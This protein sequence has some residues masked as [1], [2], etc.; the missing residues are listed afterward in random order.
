MVAQHKRGCQEKIYNISDF[1]FDRIL[2]IA[3][4]VH[5]VSVVSEILVERTMPPPHSTVADCHHL[6]KQSMVQAARQARN[7]SHVIIFCGCS[8]ETKTL[9]TQKENA[10]S[11]RNFNGDKLFARSI[12]AQTFFTFQP[13]GPT[14][15]S[16]R[17]PANLKSSFGQ[18]A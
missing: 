4:F 15:S 6:T 11:H 10:K 17:A 5:I 12:R 16:G 1:L 18:W 7:A 14:S 9:K 13:C 3:I 2:H 8:R